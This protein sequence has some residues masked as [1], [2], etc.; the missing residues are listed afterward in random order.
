MLLPGIGVFGT[1]NTARILVPLLRSKGFTVEAIWDHCLEAAESAAKELSI[2]YYTNRVDEVLLRQDVHLVCIIC[3]PN[4]HAQIAV[5]ALGIGKHVLCDRPAGLT[6]SEVLKMVR[7]AQYYPSLI[8]IIAHGLRFLPAF[9]QMKKSVKDGYIGD[10]TVVE[11]KVQCGDVIESQY[12]WTCDKVMGG[13]IV[14]AV[15]SHIIDIIAY[16]TGQRAV[17]VHGM[18]R[19][20]RK[21]TEKINGIRQITSDDFCTFQMELNKG[22]WATVTLNN[23]LPGHFVQ[24]V[25]VCGTKGHVL[26]KGGDLYGQ[27]LDSLKEEVIYLD[28]EDLKQQASFTASVVNQGYPCTQ[29]ILRQQYLLPK[30][31]TKGL[32]KLVSALKEAFV[33][34]EDN[35]TWVKEPVLLAATFEDGQYIQAV[36]DA[37]RTSS[38]NLEWV[39]VKIQTE[40]ADPNPYFSAAVRRSIIAS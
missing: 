35:Q 10:V 21:T 32:V 11:C 38:Q 27:K 20:F 39:K 37:I 33:P 9:I 26:V 2:P 18:L 19:T 31:Y 7:A 15:G 24:E 4:L 1:G 36:I 13:G 22:A 25:L 29:S 40:E 3:P 23:N 5:K 28:V 8:S 6:Q 34:V 16:V 12:N 14:S 17:K 30:L